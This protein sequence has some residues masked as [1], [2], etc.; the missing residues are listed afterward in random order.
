MTG[1]A[2]AIRRPG[3]G[4]IDGGLGMRVSRDQSVSRW[5]SCLGVRSRD[6]GSPCGAGCP[7][8]GPFG[9]VPGVRRRGGRYSLSCC[10]GWLSHSVGEEEVC[11]GGPPTLLILDLA[12]CLNPRSR[13][14]AAAGPWGTKP[15]TE[16]CTGDGCDGEDDADFEAVPTGA[17]SLEE[18]LPVVVPFGIALEIGC[19]GLAAPP[20]G[21]RFIAISDFG[22]GRRALGGGPSS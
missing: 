16:P 20:N 12:E 22:F 10:S 1:G 3:G 15:D 19:A 18:S 6:G 4:C 9:L 2:A 5:D 8:W 7:T 14:G 13:P 21:S 11:L 17:G